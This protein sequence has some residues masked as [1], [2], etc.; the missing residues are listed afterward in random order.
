MLSSPYL[1][2]FIIDVYIQPSKASTDLLSNAALVFACSCSKHDGIGPPKG[3]RYAQ[4][5]SEFGKHTYPAR[6]VLWGSL[7]E[8]LFLYPQ[9]VAD[10]G[11][12]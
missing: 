10:P 2:V 7:P 8:P 1:I 3:R 6:A 12:S 4:C 11:D 9:I 5:I